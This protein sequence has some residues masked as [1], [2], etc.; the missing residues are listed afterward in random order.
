MADREV[1]AYTGRMTEALRSPRG[2]FALAGMIRALRNGARQE[3]AGTPQDSVVHAH[4]WLPAGLATPDPARTVITLHGTDARL[5]IAPGRR[6][7]W[8]GGRSTGRG[9]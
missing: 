5:S 4:W 7:G 2:L 8:A 6:G 1:Y 9:W 3:L